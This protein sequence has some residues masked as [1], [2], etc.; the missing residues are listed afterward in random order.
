[1]L[2]SSRWQVSN[3]GLPDAEL[4]AG[5]AYELQKHFCEKLDWTRTRTAANNEGRKVHGRIR[6]MPCQ[7]RHRPVMMVNDEFHQG[8]SHKKRMKSGGCK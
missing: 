4:R 7:L 3:Q 6:R 2:R 1:M 8:V 5:G